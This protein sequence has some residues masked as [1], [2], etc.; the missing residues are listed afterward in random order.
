[1]DWIKRASAK[2]EKELKGRC[3][4]DILSE[5]SSVSEW[6][7]TGI[8]A[9]DRYVIGGHGLP[10]GKVVELYGQ[11]GAGKTSMA[12]SAA[13]HCQATG[14]SVI[15]AETE[16]A[17]DKERFS[18]FGGDPETVLVMHPESVEDFGRA[19]L[20]AMQSIPD[21]SKPTLVVWDSVAA[22]P[23]NSEVEGALE[24]SA[25]IGEKARAIGQMMRVLL[26]EL[27][28]QRA[29]LLAVNQMRQTIG[30]YIQQDVTPGG[31]AIKFAASV[32]LKLMG[33]K[34]VKDETGHTGKILKVMAEKTRWA[35]PYRSTEVKLNYSTGWDNPWTTF[36]LA[37]D[38]GLVP[39]GDRVSVA[40][41]EKA[42]EL[43]NWR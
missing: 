38:L 33:G 34:A 4:T 27:K 39:E 11:P 21:K 32:R 14:G 13:I 17:L 22:T 37:K 42:R 9:V 23:T 7:P 29:T 1:M 18:L 19:S 3:P 16:E 43:L 25:R 26:K 2:I 28:A 20:L 10:V 31:N 8:D 15:W 24:G 30:A 5:E 12:M 41:L 40:N 35:P 6:I 36:Q